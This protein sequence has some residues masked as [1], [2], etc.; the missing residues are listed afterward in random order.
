MVEILERTKGRSKKDLPLFAASLMRLD[1][2]SHCLLPPD[3]SLRW[4]LSWLSGL[5]TRS[6]LGL[7]P[8]W[9]SSLQ[10]ADCGTS[11]QN[12][13][14]HYNKPVN[15]EAP[16]LYNKPVA[17]PLSRSRFWRTM[18][19]TLRAAKDQTESELFFIPGECTLLLIPLLNELEN[20]AFA[21]SVATH[22]LGAAVLIWNGS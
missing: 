12:A 18:T 8:S 15:K 19:S 14:M 1:I 6:Q 3:W 2:A 17:L 16:I 4:Q 22:Q 7:Q 20:S 11:L 9:V 13:P 5:Q 21:K 10:T